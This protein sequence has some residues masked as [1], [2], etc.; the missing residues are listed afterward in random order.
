MCVGRAT[1]TWGGR[2]D[3]DDDDDDDRY[4]DKLNHRF[5]IA[6]LLKVVRNDVAHKDLV[7]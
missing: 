6:C 3:D 7:S 4:Y 2:R 1:T 5:H